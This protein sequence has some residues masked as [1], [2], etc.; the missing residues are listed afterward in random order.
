MGRGSGNRSSI[1]SGRALTE[2]GVAFVGGEVG[3]GDAAGDAVGVPPAALA[4][5]GEPLVPPRPSVPVEDPADLVDVRRGRLEEAVGPLGRRRGRGPR[6][7]LG[8]REKH[9]VELVVV[10]DAAADVAAPGS[11]ARWRGDSSRA[12]LSLK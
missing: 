10:A 4:E 5:A 1:H 11:P 9:G 7:V 8:S 12:K 3:G 6:A 2:L